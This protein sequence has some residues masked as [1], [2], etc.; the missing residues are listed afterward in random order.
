MEHEG[1]Q[2]T[3][4]PSA[5]AAA[6]TRDGAAGEAAGERAVGGSAG[7]A[8]PA[9][10]AV[11]PAV[12]PVPEPASTTAAVVART[13]DQ[14]A[15]AR[16]VIALE[17]HPVTRQARRPAGSEGHHDAELGTSYTLLEHRTPARF[18]V[19]ADHPGRVVGGRGDDNTADVAAARL[20]SPLANDILVALGE[21]VNQRTRGQR[22]DVD[23][24]DAR[25]VSWGVAELLEHVGRGRGVKSYAAMI[26][27]A[28]R[29]A[30]VR[31]T[32]SGGAWRRG[33]KR[34]R[35]HS[36]V[37]FGLI[38]RLEIVGR[39]DAPGGARLKFTISKEFARRLAEDF[40]LME[41]A[42][43]WRLEGDM[44]RRLYRLLDSARHLVAAKGPP[45]RAAGARPPVVR[46]PVAYLRDRLPVE[47]TKTV[48]VVRKLARYHEELVAVGFLAAEP[49]YEPCT[50]DDL[51]H[52][53]THPGR[54]AK[55]ISACYQFAPT[56]ARE[57][58]VARVEATPGSAAAPPGPRPGAF[59]AGGQIAGLGNRGGAVQGSLFAP[60]AAPL[61]SASPGLGATS[62][63]SPG[64]R[65]RPAPPSP[66][67]ADRLADL[68]RVLPDSVRHVGVCKLAAEALADDDAWR[69]CVALARQEA[70]DLPPIAKL[71]VEVR[72]ELL[73]RGLPVPPRLYDR[74]TQRA[75]L[76]V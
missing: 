41:T 18:V 65:P 48:Q 56:L 43:Y 31:I 9:D 68:S 35:V 70:G 27:T 16:M 20:P 73:R 54:G 17:D 36:E 47:E 37:I 58:E 74:D 57:E 55:L 50:A 76:G 24:D 6:E 26:E 21:V 42:G 67:L 10:A 2:R 75:L 69:R 13:L 71:V 51:R 12:D 8:T 38:D 3:V 40:R 59:V 46:V 49:T 39:A 52:F 63:G 28:R 5:D 19:T 29:L 60:T 23:S 72:A 44:A 62:G 34:G 32:A 45:P 15:R 64:A 11:D 61:P 25:T 30:K 4:P 7:G 53:P 14:M 1:E 66:D 33:G 22:W